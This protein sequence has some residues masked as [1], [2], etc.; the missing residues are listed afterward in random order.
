MYSFATEANFDDWMRQGFVSIFVNFRLDSLL[1]AGKR[2][3]PGRAIDWG[4]VRR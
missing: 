1:Q 4:K 3:R 2:L